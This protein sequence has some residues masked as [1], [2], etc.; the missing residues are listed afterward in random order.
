MSLFEPKT[1][2]DPTM[3]LSDTPSFR[4][5][6]KAQRD[7]WREQFIAMRDPT[8]Y[9]FAEKW[10]EGGYR[11]YLSLASSFVASKDLAEWKDALEVS[12]QSEGILRIAQQKDS[13]QAGKWLADRGWAEQKDKRSKAAKRAT[14]KAHSD[15]QDDMHRL[16]LSL[17]KK[18]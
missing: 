16:G 2:V 13:F 5:A 10:C 6:G 1:T 9:A 8:G 17:V 7:F 18:G 15:V 11:Q 12:L 14:E 3:K 4:S